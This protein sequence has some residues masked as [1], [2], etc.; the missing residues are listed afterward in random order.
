[1]TKNQIQEI[2]NK[3]KEDLISIKREIEEL[4]EK[5]KPIAP[6]CSIGRLT[7]QEMIQEQQ[8]NEHA[9]HEAQIRVNRLAYAFQKVDKDAYGVCAECEE[10]ILFER[11][12][13]LPESTH[14]VA[15]KSE[16]G[17]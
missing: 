10:E 15:C 3:I 13:L 5:T 1:M 4:L 8:V 2:K 6:D 7:R 9:L 14:C 12:M 11:L 16:L 17:I